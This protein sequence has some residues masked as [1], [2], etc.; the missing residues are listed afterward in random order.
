MYISEKISN[1]APSGYIPWG[2]INTHRPPPIHPRTEEIQKR[3]DTFPWQ[4]S[5]AKQKTV[6]YAPETFKLWS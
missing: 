4:I 2:S 6:H 5:M 3:A 1:C